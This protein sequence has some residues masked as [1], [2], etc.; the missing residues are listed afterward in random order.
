ML[1]KVEKDV[2]L[3]KGLGQVVDCKFLISK[4]TSKGDYV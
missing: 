4:L 2:T 1:S 3:Y